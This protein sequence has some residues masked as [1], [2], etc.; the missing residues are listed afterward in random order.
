[1]TET[2]PRGRH[3]RTGCPRQSRGDSVSIQVTKQAAQSLYDAA[4][5]ERGEDAVSARVRL[6]DIRNRV[7]AS[8]QLAPFLMRREDQV[9]D[10]IAVLACRRLWKEHAA[11][12]RLQA[13]RLPLLS[14]ARAVPRTG[15]IH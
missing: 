3:S 5:G 15:R 14:A 11:A 6:Q 1:M 12:S 10:R 9:S 8:M 13:G 4:G 2:R 7:G